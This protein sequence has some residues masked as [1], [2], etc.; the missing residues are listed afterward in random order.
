[1]NVVCLLFMGE[2][3]MEAIAVIIA[4][5]ALMWPTPAR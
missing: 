3:V 4:I 1:M 5:I 2:V